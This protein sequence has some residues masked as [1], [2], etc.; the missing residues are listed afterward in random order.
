MLSG[1]VLYEKMCINQGKLEW[2]HK[3][4]PITNELK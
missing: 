1:V 3:L 4:T 2:K